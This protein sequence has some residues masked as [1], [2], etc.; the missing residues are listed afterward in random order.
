M[1]T[2]TLN[3]HDWLRAVLQAEGL[4]AQ[5]KNVASVLAVQFANDE[6]G[7]LNPRQQ[8]LADYLKVH[9]DT[10]KRVMRELRNAGWLMSIGDGGRGRAPLLRL[11]TPGK[12]VAFPASKRG[13]EMPPQ[14]EKRGAS[15]QG[16]GGISTPPQ[17]KD[18]QALEQKGARAGDDA[19]PPI[20]TQ[21]R[22]HR[23]AGN[24]TDGARVVPKDRHGPLNAWSDWLATERLPKLCELPVAQRSEKGATFFWLPSLNPPTCE[25]G[26]AE[27]RAY[28]VVA[29]DGD[30][31]R[32][33]A[34]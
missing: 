12:I 9:V 14:A 19:P 4:S 21:Y 23:F 28:F 7:Q 18:K 20:V 34:Q 25:R 15:V 8:T 11:L 3:R 26:R 33:A 31:A 29:L 1:T 13:A 17:Y 16:K 5:A 32:R 30:A 2:S 10:V 22:E 24:P 27:A 6:T